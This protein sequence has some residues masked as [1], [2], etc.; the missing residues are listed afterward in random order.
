MS[1]VPMTY[2]V[3]ATGPESAVEVFLSLPRFRADGVARS[4]LRRESSAYL[5]RLPSGEVFELRRR[6][7]RPARQLMLLLA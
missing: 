3:I 1:V 4:L 2:T 5:L 7:P 6:A